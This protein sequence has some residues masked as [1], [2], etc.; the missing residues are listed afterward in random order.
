[1]LCDV[2][3]YSLVYVCCG[4]RA[5]DFRWCGAV[6]YVDLSGERTTMFVW[7][8]RETKNRRV[9]RFFNRRV[10]WEVA[11]VSVG[12]A[13]VVAKVKLKETSLMHRVPYCPSDPPDCWHEIKNSKSPDTSGHCYAPLVTRGRGFLQ[14]AWLMQGLGELAPP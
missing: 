11:G 2:V 10:R 4:G 13:D 7:G 8:K 14:P 9:R 3:M 6:R 5:C 1:M 12:R